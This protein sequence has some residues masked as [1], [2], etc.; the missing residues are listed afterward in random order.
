MQTGKPTDGDGRKKWPRGQKFTLSVAGAEAEVAYRGAVLGSRSSGRTAL[1]TALA[2]WAGP[3]R[4]APGDGV[5]LA[6]LSG[7]RVGLPTLCE[8][9]ETSGIVPEE[10]RAAVGRLVDA[11]IVEPVPLASQQPPN[12]VP[13]RP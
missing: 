6:E 11:G 9:L 12:G 4:L 7:K 2:A 1:D 5:V 8:A 13:F 3:R 10:V